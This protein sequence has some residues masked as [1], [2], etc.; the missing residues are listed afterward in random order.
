ML[1]II[2][3]FKLKSDIVLKGLN[4]KYWALS[5]TTGNQYKLN[6]VAYHMLNELVETNSVKGLVDAMRELYKVSEQ[7]IESDCNAL[8]EDLIKGGLV[9]EVIK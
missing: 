6:E 8:I 9:E 3:C 2:N 5:T 4:G 7:E 1:D